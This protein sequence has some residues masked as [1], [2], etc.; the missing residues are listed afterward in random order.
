[1]TAAAAM[2]VL[3]FSLA[4]TIGLAQE[5]TVRAIRA[6]ASRVRRWG[7]YILVTVGL[8]TAA[9]AVFPGFLRPLLF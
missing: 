5:R 2:V 7:G 3:M 8:W 4:L 1:M 9:L 6:R